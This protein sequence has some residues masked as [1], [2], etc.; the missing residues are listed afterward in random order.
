MR[1]GEDGEGGEWGPA[2]RR[3]YAHAWAVVR[4]SVFRSYGAELGES[5]LDYTGR[6][7]MARKKVLWARLSSGPK[8]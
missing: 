2:R 4:S 1:S 3:A 7:G 5:A 6:H 8:N